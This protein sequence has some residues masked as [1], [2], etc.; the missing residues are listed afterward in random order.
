MPKRKKAIQYA[1]K[2]TKEL[3]H[4]YGL[5]SLS[6]DKFAKVVDRIL[7]GRFILLDLRWPP[8]VQNQSG[9]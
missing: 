3:W 5:Q 2:G 8:S 1:R 4:P 9:L 6:T 7:G